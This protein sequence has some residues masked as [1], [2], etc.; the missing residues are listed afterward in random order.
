MNNASAVMPQVVELL[1]SLVAFPTVSRTPNTALQEWLG[2][3]LE[4]CGARVQVVT[5]VHA[6][7]ANLVASLGPA[8]PGG[9]LLSGHTDVVPPGEGWHTDPFTLTAVD[10]RLY[11]RGTADMKG[12]FAA[13]LVAMRTIDPATL[14]APV[15]V[16]ASYDEE[17]GCQ[18]VRD[19]LPQLAVDPTIRP[20][21]VVIGEPTMMRPRHSHLGK[22]MYRVV[23]RA[24]EAHSSRA[25]TAPSAIAGAAHLVEVLS[26]IQ[27]GCPAARGDDAPAYTVNC[28]TIHGGTAANVIAAECE[29]VFEVR[30]DTHHD[31]VVVLAPFFA[32][33]DALH[34]R[35]TAVGGGVDRHLVTSYPAMATDTSSPP[36]A[37]AVRLADAGASVALDFGTEGG[38]LS[39]VVDA[40]VMICGPGDIGDAHRPDEWVA[41][42]QLER[43]VHVV[44]HLITA[45]CSDAR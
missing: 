11:G 16:L 6:G 21:L 8:V 2:E 33:A 35:L 34:E 28:G 37:Q 26:A 17:V 13:V 1:R 9:L 39:A 7:N 29:V 40:P 4:A 5:G 41:V 24:A 30:H 19:V 38:L 20:A 23:V 14:R 15:H 25:A 45:F 44:R 10:D 18:G 27:T 32:A 36:F 12:F 43:C 22:Q 31:P 42:D 3:Q